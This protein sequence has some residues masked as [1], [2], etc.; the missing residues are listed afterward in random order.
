MPYTSDDL[1]N[2]VRMR[3]QLPSASND[4][5]FTNADLLELANEEF[6]TNVLPEIRKARGNYYVAS[7]DYTVA[8]GVSAYN[9]P[10][11]AQGASLRDVTFVNTDGTG[12]SLPEIPLEDVDYYKTSGSTWWSTALCYCI[13][14][15]K[16]LLRPEPTQAGTLRLRYYQRPGRLVP[17][18]EAMKVTGFGPNPTQ[19]QGDVPASWGT[20][21]TFDIVLADPTF[22]TIATDETVTAVTTGAGGSVT[23]T[24]PYPTELAVGDY[25]SLATESAVVQLTAELQPALISATCV[26]VLESMG[27]LQSAQLAQGL[28]QRQMQQ[29]V[30]HIQPRNDGEQPRIINRRGPL[31][32]SRRWQ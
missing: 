3:C 18:S 7:V 20:S 6:L 27:D 1:I 12:F 26:R 17:T 25:I 22:D 19:V 32:F 24:N 10:S 21:S 23:F 14:N 31:R 28:Y 4:G 9:I 29:A 16:V 15:N 5:K 8:S 2:A 13:E 30:A 11:R